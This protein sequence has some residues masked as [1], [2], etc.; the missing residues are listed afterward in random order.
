MVRRMQKHSTR[1]RFTPD[2][3]REFVAAYRRSDLTQAGFAAK[4]GISL[5]GFRLWLKR[6][7]RESGDQR[8]LPAFIEVPRHIPEPLWQTSR[9]TSLRLRLPKDVCL[10]LPG[11]YPVA[12][13]IHLLRDLVQP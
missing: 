10:E 2:E 4:I 5:A 7:G 3:R 11:D 6:H 13:L 9:D 8:K 12:Q 1:R